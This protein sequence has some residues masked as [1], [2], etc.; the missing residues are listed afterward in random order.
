MPPYFQTKAVKYYYAFFSAG[1]A[2]FWPLGI[3]RL[4]SATFIL[5]AASY[6]LF[7]LHAAA[8]LS[9]AKS[10]SMCRQPRLSLND[11]FRRMLGKAAGEYA[12][13][14]VSRSAQTTVMRI[15]ACLIAH[16]LILR[17]HHR[18]REVDQCQIVEIDHDMP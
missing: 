13:H 18:R 11:V 12:G 17:I 5:P 7:W 9:R 4:S 2:M 14:F 1:V 16:Y 10:S 3:S 6:T 8:V 15:S